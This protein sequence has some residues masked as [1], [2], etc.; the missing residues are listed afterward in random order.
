MSS[1][2]VSLKSPKAFQEELPIIDAVYIFSVSTKNLVFHYLS[3]KSAPSR[4]DIKES[5]RVKQFVFPQGWGDIENV[6]D[7]KTITTFKEFKFCLK[8]DLGVEQYAYCIYNTF[9]S[10][11]VVSNYSWFNLLR[12]FLSILAIRWHLALSQNSILYKDLKEVTQSFLSPVSKRRS[13]RFNE[14]L[15]PLASENSK[16]NTPTTPLASNQIDLISFDPFEMELE[17]NNINESSNPS[18]NSQKLSIDI[19]LDN[20]DPFEDSIIFNPNSTSNQISTPISVQDLI[21]DESIEY[22][23]PISIEQLIGNFI[24]SLNSSPFPFPGESFEIR[25]KTDTSF[26]DGSHIFTR[27][28]DDEIPDAVGLKTLFSFLNTKQI[29]QLFQCVLEERRILVVGDTPASVSDCIISLQQLVYPFKWQHIFI[30]ILPYTLIDYVMAP[31]PF[32][33]GVHSSFMNSILKM[34]LENIVILDTTKKLVCEYSKDI[35]T[36]MIDIT[37]PYA[38]NLFTKIQEILPLQE[39]DYFDGSA[40]LE[41]FVDYLVNIFGSCRKYMHLDH[42]K[43]KPIFRENDFFKSLPEYSNLF[44]FMKEAQYF[45]QWIQE[46]LKLFEKN[47]IPTGLFERKCAIKYPMY[48]NISYSNEESNLQQ[49]K[50]KISRWASAFINK[51]SGAKNVPVIQHQF[52]KNPKLEKV[53][54]ESAMK[55]SQLQKKSAE[56]LQNY[57]NKLVMQMKSDSM[58]E[59]YE[60]I[61]TNQILKR[62]ENQAQKE[63]LEELKIEK[64]MNRL[65]TDNESNDLVWEQ[66]GNFSNQFLELQSILSIQLEDLSF[67]ERELPPIPKI[68]A[69]STPEKKTPTQLE[70]LLSFEDISNQIETQDHH[71]STSIQKQSTI[72]TSDMLDLKFNTTEIPVQNLHIQQNQKIHHINKPNSQQNLS[73]FENIE[74]ESLDSL[75]SYDTNISPVLLSQKP[76]HSKNDIIKNNVQELDLFELSSN[77]NPA[78]T[79]QKTI[80]ENIQNQNLFDFDSFD[81]INL[82]PAILPKKS[83][84]QNNN[85]KDLFGFDPF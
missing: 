8:D 5:K 40:I 11:C 39:D 28:L 14:P 60:N 15:T 64:Q 74:L 27:P 35:G 62:Q 57:K 21:E 67:P 38:P 80:N 7:K 51:V 37:L 47:E 45:E 66:D 9:F 6:K 48:Y 2:D 46:R 56:A 72:N 33:I 44:K 71:L 50:K 29:I 41:M 58:F 4:S 20:L 73:L 43:K 77:I 13:M 17:F 63:N 18:Q 85:D 55:L 32:I 42:E 49:S 61:I 23:L 68:Q 69:S 16:S 75:S 65:L 52:A 53:A 22:T 84:I 70:D 78:L 3:S 26:L 82:E 83:P 30:P 79:S 59:R 25:S 36:K 31:M 76:I 10:F 24:D 19:P 12:Y 1:L 81:D 54:R 34:P